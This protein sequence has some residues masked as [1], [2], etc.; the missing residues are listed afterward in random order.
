VN[1]K[2]APPDDVLV[3]TV[4]TPT[5]GALP[6]GAAKA[7]VARLRL[8]PNPMTTSATFALI[9]VSPVAS[10]NLALT[11]EAYVRHRRESSIGD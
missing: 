6:T 5:G 9:G 3:V 8:S 4:G 1:A 2:P 11:R 7:G 10:Q